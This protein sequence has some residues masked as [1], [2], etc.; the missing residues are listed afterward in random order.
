MVTTTLKINKELISNFELGFENI[1]SFFR[2]NMKE[3]DLLNILLI[4]ENLKFYYSMKE[5]FNT[6]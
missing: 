3:S 2:P 5:F 1:L 6:P 4:F